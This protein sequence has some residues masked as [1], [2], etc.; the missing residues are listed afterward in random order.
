[1]KRAL[2]ALLL[3]LGG[4]RPAAAFLGLGSKP[5]RLTNERELFETA[6]YGDVVAA[7]TPE[8][9][10]RLK[11]TERRDGYMLLAESYERMGDLD[12]ALGVY[13]LA[14][15]LF[16]RDLPLMTQLGFLLHRSGLH[17][18]ARPMFERVLAIHPNNAAAQVGM[19][20][21][22]ARLGFL[23]RSAGFYER[24]LELQAGSAPLWRDYAEVLLK[25]RDIKTAVLACQRS[26][27]LSQDPDTFVLCAQALRADGRADEA[28]LRLEEAL[29]SGSGGGWPRLENARLLKALWLADAGRLDEANALAEAA[30][31]KDSREPL[32]LWVRARVGLKRDR[33]N[34]AVRD[35]E[36]AAAAGKRAPFVARAAAALLANL[37]GVR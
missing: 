30:L 29:A 34:A 33:Y 8:K 9:L 6:R 25:K 15:R 10:S 28:L 16:P 18:Q 31:A 14:V 1:M 24:A 7:L 17:E 3:A 21:I 11:K 19:A 36:T 22:N 35:L 20:E 2:L 27:N 23:E 32:A 12:R 37:K 5:L 4:A 26:L 13:Q